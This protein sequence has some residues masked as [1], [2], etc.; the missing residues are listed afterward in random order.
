MKGTSTLAKAWKEDAQRSSRY[1][2]HVTKLSQSVQALVTAEAPDSLPVMQPT[3]QLLEKLSAVHA[4]IAAAKLRV[5]NDIRDIVERYRVVERISDQRRSAGKALESSKAKLNEYEDEVAAESKR[6][7]YNMK[8]AEL[9]LAKLRAAKKAALIRARDLTV[10]L[11]GEQKKFANFVFRRTREAYARFGATL[12]R[13]CPLELAILMK[14]IDALQKAR[15]GEVLHV[16]DIE[17]PAVV[18][19]TLADADDGAEFVAESPVLIDD[20]ETTAE[21]VFE[22]VS[23]D[24]PVDVGDAAPP[25]PA[26]VSAK[27]GPVFDSSAFDGLAVVAPA[28]PAEKT[29]IADGPAAVVPKRKLFDV[30][31]PEAAPARQAKSDLWTGADVQEVDEEKAFFEVELPPT[32]EEPDMKP[33]KAAKPP[34]KKTRGGRKGHSILSP[35]DEI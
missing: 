5:S 11:I 33:K 3:I 16:P 29:L 9:N 4:D 18:P 17:V 14:L 31:E 13:D 34:A 2:A 35:F 22:P 25:K 12:S 10:R 28:R 1:G 27:R 19:L 26:D 32:P 8:R 7:D 30:I 6:K 15:S 21:P 20:V 24:G 23:L